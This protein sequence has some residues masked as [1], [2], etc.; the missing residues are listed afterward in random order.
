MPP[1]TRRASKRMAREAE[2]G[3]AEAADDGVGVSPL[4]GSVLRDAGREPPAAGGGARGSADAARFAPYPRPASATRPAASSE[5]PAERAQRMAEQAARAR[6][7]HDQQ[8]AVL[9]AV[10][11][12]DAAHRAVLQAQAAAKREQAAHEQSARERMEALAQQQ[13]QHDA[14]AVEQLEAARR[15]E[16]VHAQAAREAAVIEEQAHAERETAE[17]EAEEAAAREQRWLGEAATLGRATREAH[18]AAERQRA[19]REQAAAEHAAREQAARDAQAA[20]EVAAA[21]EAGRQQAIREAQVRAERESAARAA[22][23]SNARERTGVPLLTGHQAA[24]QP[25]LLHMSAHASGAGGDAVHFPQ[26]GGHRAG[27]SNAP[28]AFGGGGGYVGAV[29]I[30]AAAVSPVR[31]A[32]V[33]QADELRMRPQV[34]NTSVRLGALGAQAADDNQGHARRLPAPLS[35]EVTMHPHSEAAAIAADAVQAE[36]AATAK[37]MADASGS[38]PVHMGTE[39]HLSDYLGTQNLG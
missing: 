26:A 9:E 10:R 14:Q 4:I 37:D 18:E 35:A 19:A 13:A 38:V 28:A 39:P 24:A 29:G 25:A 15:E 16:M 22:A 32:G 1:L 23:E 31:A 17:H 7:A 11:E 36:A 5:Q 3:A 33:Q 12:H 8:A 6:A 27:A 21:E 30:S 34:A 20:R 2:E